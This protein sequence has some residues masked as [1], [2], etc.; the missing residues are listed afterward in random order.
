MVKFLVWVLILHSD[1]CSAVRIFHLLLLVYIYFWGKWVLGFV[2]VLPKSFTYNKYCSR[3]QIARLELIWW[4]ICAHKC[5]NTCVCFM[6]FFSNFC[7]EFFLGNLFGILC[8]G[9]SHLSIM[10]FLLKTVKPLFFFCCICESILWNSLLPKTLTL[11]DDNCMEKTKPLK[12]LGDWFVCRNITQWQQMLMQDFAKEENR[13][14]NNAA[15]AG[16]GQ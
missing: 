12:L 11:D 1:Y 16:S 5:D 13:D 6:L 2:G 3:Y 10:C 7:C 9:V 4:S 15:A 14:V 8:T